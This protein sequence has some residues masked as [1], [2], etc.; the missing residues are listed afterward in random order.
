MWNLTIMNVLPRWPARRCQKSS[1]PRVVIDSTISSASSTGERT[2]IKASH[3]TMFQPSLGD[4]VGGRGVASRSDEGKTVGQIAANER[5]GRWQGVHLDHREFLVVVWMAS[6]GASRAGSLYHGGA[7]LPKK[8]A[9]PRPAKIFD[10]GG[11]G[12]L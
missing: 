11:Y 3:L 1:L 4:L 8:L 7:R 9:S 5:D 12:C 10:G 6:S 2:R